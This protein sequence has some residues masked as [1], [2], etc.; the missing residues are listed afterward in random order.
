M[1]KEQAPA[2]QFYPKD[3]LSDIHFKAMSLKERGAYFTLL[4]V[5]WLERS[6]PAD[7]ETLARVL[8][9]PNAE[10]KKLWIHL[11]PCFREEDGRL[12]HPRLELER[13]KQETFRQRQSDKG[14]ASAARRLQPE[15]NHGST[16]PQPAPVQPE[17]NSSIS[18]LPSSTPVK[19]ETGSLSPPADPFTDATI[20]ERAGR[21]IERYAD[22]LYP[23]HR[24]GARYVVNPHRD[25]REAVQLCATWTDDARLDKIA[26]IFLT[27][28]HKFAEEG[29]RTL[30]QFRSLASWCDNRL[31]EWETKQGVA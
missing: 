14:R 11:A 26:T 28:D 12:V 29:S 20:T 9:V 13:E 27:T 4:A 22:D 5:C 21:F 10:F 8:S 3:L 6:L 23:K 30:A 24:K 18:H 19:R 1:A 2:F 7:P 17:G 25:Y 31:A 16:E 15:G